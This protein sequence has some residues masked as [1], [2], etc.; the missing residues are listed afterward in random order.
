MTGIFHHNSSLVS[1]YPHST[2]L[3]LSAIY[4]TFLIKLKRRLFLLLSYYFV[5]LS[6]G[7]IKNIQYSCLFYNKHVII[8]LWHIVQILNSEH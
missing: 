5:E 6:Q 2:A 7:L 1:F 3:F 4:I 8:K